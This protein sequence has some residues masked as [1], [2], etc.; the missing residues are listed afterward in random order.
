MEEERAMIGKKNQRFDELAQADLHIRR[1]EHSALK[2]NADP[3]PADW[4]M[5][6]IELKQRYD[7]VIAALHRLRDDLVRYEHQQEVAT[8]EGH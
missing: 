3:V 8:S 6:R 7:A 5:R 2:G 1:R 4:T